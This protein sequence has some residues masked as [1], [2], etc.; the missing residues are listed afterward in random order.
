MLIDLKSKNYL[1]DVRPFLKPSFIKTIINTFLRRKKLRPYAVQCFFEKS[2]INKSL[3]INSNRLNFLSKENYHNLNLYMNIL[4]SFTGE[5]N[6]KV[7][8]DE[9]FL[10]SKYV[11]KNMTKEDW[12]KHH[13]QL[14]SW[15]KS[16][17]EFRR[18][19]SYLK[20]NNLHVAFKSAK[21]TLNLI[22]WS[23]LYF[24]HKTILIEMINCEKIIHV[25][26]DTYLLSRKTKRVQ[27]YEILYKLFS[28]L[29]YLIDISANFYSKEDLSVCNG[30]FIYLVE[31][32]FNCITKDKKQFRFDK[33]ELRIL[34]DLEVFYKKIISN[35]CS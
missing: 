23:S 5:L 13:N 9:S 3:L 20:K 11:L 25:L 7:L 16:K 6:E 24:W 33:E 32:C 17:N 26:Y 30:F 21:K 22:S 19:L 8:V 1:N 29:D 28:K 18:S 34:N 14:N 27:F 2:L 35:D 15:Y 10:Y 31:N 12:A 4:Q